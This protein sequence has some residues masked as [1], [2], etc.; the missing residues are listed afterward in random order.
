MLVEI[1]GKRFI[2]DRLHLRSL[3]LDYIASDMNALRQF[4]FLDK[5]DIFF[6]Q[7]LWFPVWI[8]GRNWC[9]TYW[10]FQ[11]CF[12]NLENFL[13]LE[14]FDE[15]SLT[16]DIVLD[17]NKTISG[18]FEIFGNPNSDTSRESEHLF[19]IFF[20]TKLFWPLCWTVKRKIEK[21]R[22]R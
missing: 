11:Q 3:V 9:I 20:Q 14:K 7:L 15:M 16:F 18:N 8:Q 19:K 1:Y 12:H 2:V 21:I 10:I 4:L 5:W 17:H 22:F 6:S 13:I